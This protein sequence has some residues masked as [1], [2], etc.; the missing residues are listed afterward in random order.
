MPGCQLRLLFILRK[1]VTRIILL[2]IPHVGGM[3]P[4]H[5]QALGSSPRRLTTYQ[6]VT[7]LTIGLFRRIIARL[8]IRAISASPLGTVLC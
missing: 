2:L 6:V 7:H 5:A 3:T 4:Q 1:S 8:Q